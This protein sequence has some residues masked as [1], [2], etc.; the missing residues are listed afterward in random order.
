MLLHLALFS[1]FKKRSLG[2]E[3]CNVDLVFKSTESLPK[4]SGSVS[5]IHMGAQPS[6]T[7]VPGYRVVMHRTHVVHRHNVQARH[8]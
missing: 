4:D 5:S 7:S 6:V 2:L 8:S 3:R 1:F